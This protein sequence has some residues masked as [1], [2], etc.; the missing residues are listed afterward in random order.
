MILFGILKQQNY[1]IKYLNKYLNQ[2][3]YFS[4]NQLNN[5]NL[6]FKLNKNKTI[7]IINNE[8]QKREIKLKYSFGYQNYGHR[9]HIRPPGH[10]VVHY[11]HFFF[12]IIGSYAIFYL[13]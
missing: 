13:T 6:L 10:H 1:Q 5:N 3:K 11:L 9:R 12:I 8:K 2:I 4:I 7:S